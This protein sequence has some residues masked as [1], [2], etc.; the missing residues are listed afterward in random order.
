[1]EDTKTQ[2][3]TEQASEKSGPPDCRMLR[4]TAITDEEARWLITFIGC[5]TQGGVPVKA[6]VNTLVTVWEMM[7]HAN[8]ELVQ[9]LKEAAAKRSLYDAVCDLAIS[10]RMEMGPS[11]GNVLAE[12]IQGRLGDLLSQVAGSP[13]GV[14]VAPGNGPGVVD[15]PLKH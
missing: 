4:M 15:T 5:G 12:M 11:L 8:E 9:E 10:A 13:V 2:E 3:T 6:I 7:P 1:M 14:E